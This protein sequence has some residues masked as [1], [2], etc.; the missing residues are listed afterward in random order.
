LLIVDSTVSLSWGVY[1]TGK[2]GAGALGSAGGLGAEGAPG[3]AGGWSS[4]DCTPAVTPGCGTSVCPKKQA[5]AGG[6]GGKGGKGGAGGPGGGGP[7]IPLV[8]SGPE[9]TIH[10]LTLDAGPGGAGA[11][12][13]QGAKGATGERVDSK[14]L[15][16]SSATTPDAGTD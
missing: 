8:V 14:V 12:S 13:G 1:R 16:S 6:A 2:G 7:S 5:Q 10:A 15:S 4:C 11:D 9:P 3:G